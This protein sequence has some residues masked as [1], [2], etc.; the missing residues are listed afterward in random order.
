MTCP[1]CHGYK[2]R[3]SAAADAARVAPGSRFRLSEMAGAGAASTSALALSSSSSRPGAA[4]G[5]ECGHC[6]AYC[7]W[8]DESEWEEKWAKWES[9]LAYYDRTYGKLMDEWYEDV[10]NEGNLDADTPHDEGEPPADGDDG[11]LAAGWRAGERRKSLMAALVK[12]FGGHPYER[13]DAL[14]F[15]S[16]DPDKSIHDNLLALGYNNNELV[17]GRDRD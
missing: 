13:G 5:D 7:E 8:D 15:R 1:H 10:I 12:R 3:S 11:R 17:R 9:R 14:D 16:V 4:A 2:R 6:G